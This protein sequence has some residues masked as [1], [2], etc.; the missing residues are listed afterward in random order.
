MERQPMDQDKISANDANDKVLTSK[1]NK[2][3]IQ[4]NIKI[5]PIKQWEKDLNKHFSREDIQMARS[6]LKRCL[7]TLTIDT[8]EI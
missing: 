5:N 2:Q 1:I 3:L 7:N 4:L 6:H 8:R